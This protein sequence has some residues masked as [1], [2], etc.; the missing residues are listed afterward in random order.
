MYFRWSLIGFRRVSQ[1]VNE[2]GGYD[3]FK[4]IQLFESCR[5][6][7]HSSGIALELSLRSRGGFFFVLIVISK[8]KN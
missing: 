3:F 4:Q 7:Y 1:L 2:H 8:Q 5:N 6:L